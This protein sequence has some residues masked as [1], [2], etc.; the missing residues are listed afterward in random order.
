MVPAMFGVSHGALQFMV[1]ERLK[2]WRR[3]GE[4]EGGEK[5]LGS[6][7]FVV[8]SAGAKVGAGCL[9]YPY[10]VVQTRMQNFEMGYKG[11]VEC[12]QKVWAREGVRGFYKGLAPT[13]VRVLPSTCVTFLVY[14]NM[15]GY[16]GAGV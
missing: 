13:I 1:Y 15:R 9:T 6:V 11:P 14:E 12:V 5:R 7:D 3:A 4:E 8:L 16:L 2:Q 10:R